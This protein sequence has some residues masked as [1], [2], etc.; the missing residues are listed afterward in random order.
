MVRRPATVTGEILQVMDCQATLVHV[1][2][3]VGPIMFAKWLSMVRLA[4]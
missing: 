2:L 3:V 1:R 4:S